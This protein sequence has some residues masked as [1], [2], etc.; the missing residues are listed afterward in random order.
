[1]MPRVTQHQLQYT[2]GSR[3]QLSVLVPGDTT[4]ED[5]RKQETLLNSPP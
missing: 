2:S 1:M 5:E 4:R 3:Y